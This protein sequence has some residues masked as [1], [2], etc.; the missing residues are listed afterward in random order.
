VQKNI[1][2]GMKWLKGEFLKR[3]LSSVGLQPWWRGVEGGDEG[4]CI[5]RQRMAV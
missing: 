3:R 5:V 1:E 2:G 4:G